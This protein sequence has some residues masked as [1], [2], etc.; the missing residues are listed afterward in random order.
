MIAKQYRLSG[1]KIVS[2]WKIDSCLIYAESIIVLFLIELCSIINF[3]L[4]ESKR[5]NLCL[6]LDVSLISEKFT[7]LFWSEF[8][9]RIEENITIDVIKNIRD[10]I[11]I[12]SFFWVKYLALNWESEL[13]NNSNFLNPFWFLNIGLSNVHDSPMS[14]SLKLIQQ[15]NPC[16]W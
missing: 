5:F 9:Q 12:K 1:N 2:P 15:L 7:A 14:V 16:W 3:C 8:S 11:I 6:L 13:Q 10:F 4:I